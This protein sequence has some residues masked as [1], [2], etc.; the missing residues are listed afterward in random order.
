M[1]QARSQPAEPTPTVAADRLESWKEIATY[2]KRDVRTLHRWESGEGLPVHR[3]MHKRRG[4]VHAYRSELDAWRRSRGS[5][6]VESP[7]Q[8]RMLAVLPFVNLAGD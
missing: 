4:T 2:L 1:A 5:G 3:H 7:A 8:R 6:R